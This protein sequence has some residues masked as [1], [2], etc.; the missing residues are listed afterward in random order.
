M[1]R[2]MRRPI[3]PVANEPSEPFKFS[4]ALS[5]ADQADEQIT[6]DAGESSLV[7]D[8]QSQQENLT[9]EQLQQLFS[10]ASSQLVTQSD[11]KQ[12]FFKRDASIK[13]PKT[14]QIIQAP[15][16]PPAEDRKECADIDPE[17]L[18]QL[19]QQE[20]GPLIIERYSPTETEINYPLATATI[21]FNQPMIAV[22][23]LDENTNVEN[24][25]IS[26]TPNVEGRWRWTGT[27][28][29]QFEAKHRLPFATKYTLQVKKDKCVSAIG[30]KLADELSFEF[31]TTPPSVVQFTPYGTV[32][33]LKPTC[34][35]LFDQKI[36]QNQILK[37]LRVVSD[38][39]C[40]ISNNDLEL[41]D[42]AAGE[43]AL[44]GFFRSD[45]GINGRSVA[46]TFKNDLSKA[47]QYFVKVPAG[48][49]SAEGP[50]K[51]TTEW[52]N[53]F[54]TYEPLKI[55]GWYPNKNEQYQSSTN[56]GDSW[57]VTFNNALDHSTINKSIFKVE[58]E[59]TGLGIEHIE[60]N[61]QQI[62]IHNNSKPNTVYTLT[63][64]PDVLKDIHGQTLEHDFAA[65]PIQFHV[66]DSPPP[67][68]HLSGATGMIIMDPGV[69][70]EPFYPLMI[71]NYSE[72]TLCVNR[73]EPTDFRQELPCFQPYS[74]GNGKRI[75]NIHLP[76]KELV[77][78]T[79]QTNC[80]RD[81]PKEMK[82]PLK[83]YL[84]QESGVGQ[85]IILITPTQKAWNEYP[86]N[87]WEEKP[88]ISA[89]LQCTRLAIDVFH[90][91]ARGGT[92]VRFTTWITD[93]M[94]GVP[95]QQAT[96]SISNQ[97]GETNQQGLCTILQNIAEEN[98]QGK[99]LIARKGEDLCMLPDI[100]SYAS[101]VNTYVWH[102][103]NDRGLYKPK[104]EV[105]VKGYVRYLAVK[106][107]AKL[108]SYAQ[109][110]IDY[111]VHDPR[112]QQLQESKVELNSYGAFDIK[113]TL[114]DNVN[115]GEG[116]V[117]FNLP[118]SQTQTTHSFKI[119]E[120][121]RPEYEVSSSTRI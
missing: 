74:Y 105:H 16:P 69:L 46:F 12:E 68:G 118:S 1:P 107:D 31:A 82:I 99:M 101:N 5:E 52:S 4:F 9:S 121:R 106:G 88:V 2:I 50:L 34:C 86:H 111:T 41:L 89:W 36:D 72:V 108:P 73:V 55:I 117:T 116:W 102:V 58:P 81:E 24:L 59:V 56:P 32:A 47:T 48:C 43:K 10:R 103:F 30:G 23:T 78:E 66:H 84:A 77:N 38:N 70:D 19:A 22:S 28:T 51:S 90:S 87:K 45:E 64:Q 18:K 54:Q 115:L 61:N 26:L 113:F 114:P 40:E 29:V 95:V 80:E 110:V 20:A 25:G 97:K 109:G 13:A 112:G 85:L 67:Q 6:T 98:N 11:D 17:Q 37:H 44:E 93:L 7:D 53:S 63:I 57:W 71:Y 39:G 94:T 60:Y 76:G 79:I 35:L 119:Q 96:V 62:T 33:T 83:S 3:Q 91:S 14:G 49:P 8:S 15:F 100:Y 104:E 92:S 120:F 42:E 65:Q 21:T 75:A 27:K